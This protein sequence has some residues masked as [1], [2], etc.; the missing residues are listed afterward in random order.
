MHRIQLADFEIA[1]DRPLTIITG[2]CQ[3]EGLD[4]SLML[5]EKLAS[6]EPGYTEGWNFGPDPSDTR[7]VV[8]VASAIVNALGQGRLDIAKTAPVLHEA[9]L[10]QLDSTKAGKLGW[11]P[12]LN[13]RETID[14]TASWYGGWVAGRAP[15][16]MC[17][18]QVNMYM[19]KCG[20]NDE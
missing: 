5:A 10:L 18:E 7:P 6:G 17:L 19:G 14:M 2:P 12:N 1:N 11:G 4:H 3:L 20:D 9:K 8:E 16:A 13:F 15:A